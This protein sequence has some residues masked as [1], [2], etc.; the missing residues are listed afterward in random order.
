MTQSITARLHLVH[1][2]N[3]NSMP[4]NRQRSN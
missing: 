2:M 1:L 4:G 3:A